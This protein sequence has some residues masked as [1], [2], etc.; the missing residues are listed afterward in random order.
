MKKRDCSRYPN[1]ALSLQRDFT[2]D[3]LG[4]IICWNPTGKALHEI[5]PR[6]LKSSC[7]SCKQS[8]LILLRRLLP[9]QCCMRFSGQEI[10]FIRHSCMMLLRDHSRQHSSWQPWDTVTEILVQH[11]CH[12]NPPSIPMRQERS[13]PSPNPSLLHAPAQLSVPVQHAKLVELLAWLATHLQLHLTTNNL[14]KEP[15]PHMPPTEKEYLQRIFLADPR[16]HLLCQANPATAWWSPFPALG[17]R[18]VDT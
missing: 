15:H 16:I 6:I 1:K 12:H 3:E 10:H 13:G 11:A 8:G 7:H 5:M 14:R 17:S 2:C 4:D 9:P 18:C